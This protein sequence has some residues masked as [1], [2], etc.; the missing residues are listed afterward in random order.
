VGN[1]RLY[2]TLTRITEGKGTMADLDN[3]KELGEIIK[4]TALCGLGQTSPNP[5]LSTMKYFW[6]EYVAH[7]QEKKCPAGVCTALLSYYV[8]PDKCIG[9]TACKRVCP[10]ACISG[11]VKKVHEIDQSRCIKCGACQQACRFGAI[12]KK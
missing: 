4:D 10:V 9:C 8:L 2:E 12:V 11:E 3:L 5:V 1:R 7:V 6:D